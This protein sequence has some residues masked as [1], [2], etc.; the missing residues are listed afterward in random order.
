MPNPRVFIGLA[1][2][3]AL[4]VLSTA[5]AW[6]VSVQPGWPTTTGHVVSGDPALGD[7]D[8]DGQLEVVV[9]CAD[10]RVYAWHE[11]GTPVAGWPKDVGAQANG[12]PV[13]ADLDG[14]DYLEVVIGDESGKVHAWHGDGT[15]VAG[16]PQATGGKIRGA[17]AVGDLDGDGE[18]EVI[19]GSYDHWVYAWHRDGRAVAGWP[20]STGGPVV[21]SPAVG[22]LDGDGHLEV[23]IGSKGGNVYAWHGDGTPV[24]GWPRAT[25]SAVDSSPAIGDIDGDGHLEVVVGSNDDYVYAWHSDGAAV[26]GWPK[27]TVGPVLLSPALGDLDGDGDLEVMVASYDDSNKNVYAWH[28]DGTSV[29]GWP[30]TTAGILLVSSPALGDLDGDGNLEVVIADG[31]GFVYA[32]H[33]NGTAA[34]GWPVFVQQGMVFTSPALGDLDGDSDLEVVVGANPGVY[35]WSCEV[36]TENALPWPMFHHDAQHTGRFGATPSTLPRGFAFGGVMP[37]SGDVTT[38]FTWRVKYWDEANVPPTGVWVATWSHQRNGPRWRLMT[39]SDPADTDYTDGKWYQLSDYAEEGPQGFR[40]AASVGGTWLY[41]PIPAPSYRI[42][43]DVS[44][45]ILSSGYVTPAAG[46]T[47]TEFSYRVKYWHTDNLGPDVV[48]VAI[49][50]QSRKSSDWYQMWPMDPADTNYRDGK[51]YMFTQRWHPLDSSAHAFRLAARR[52]SDWAY[53]PSPAGNYQGGPT[54]GP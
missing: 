3:G 13:L 27:K 8:G 38:E 45:V 47:A 48:W 35:A 33:G 25:S 39:A 7:L 51:W 14:D 26:A 19:L 10:D 32:W 36:A 9:G 11:D 44:P 24:A 34:A 5:S 46:T 6:C 50:S 52:G 30:Q 18:P 16:W 1:L 29:A 12:K 28:G 54:V 2:V 49:W 4:A 21:S 41:S 42:G 37:S 20:Q 22:D 23:V 31:A 15:S 40:F 43:P 53:W 17:P